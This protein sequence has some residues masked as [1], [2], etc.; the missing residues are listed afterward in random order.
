M[1]EILPGLWRFESLHPE[2]TEEEG[3]EDGWEPLVGWWALAS[4]RGIVLIDPLVEDWEELDRLIADA[5]GCAGVIRTI[6]WHERSVAA[7]A[8]RYETQ[9]WAMAPPE[10]VPAQPLDRAIH[11][12][13]EV[14]DGLRATKVERAD[15]IALW[16]PEQRAL[17]FGDAMIRSADGQLR[18]CPDSWLQP[19]GG[20]SRLR[21]I[22][23]GL[24]SLPAEHVLVAHGPHVP[25]DGP[26]ALRS[27][28]A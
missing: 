4:S 11:D 5:G 9:V 12:G 26:E 2:W 8:R 3:G 16:L 19:Q 1:D 7:A 17:L 25:G 14:F 20:T 28:L 6:H 24:A 27:A 22:L 21:E 13:D 10:G 15:E 23:R 18:V